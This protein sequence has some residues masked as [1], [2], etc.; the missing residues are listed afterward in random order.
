M[1]ASLSLGFLTV[2]NWTRK[3]VVFW[4]K[5]SSVWHFEKPVNFVLACAGGTAQGV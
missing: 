5:Y 2:V 4:V 3:E 1:Q